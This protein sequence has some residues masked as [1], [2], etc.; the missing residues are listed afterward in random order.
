M[1]KILFIIFICPAFAFAQQYSLNNF[2]RN[3]LDK[4][5]TNNSV[6]IHSSFLPLNKATIG[7]YEIDDKFLF[8]KSEDPLIGDRIK[9]TWLWRVIRYEDLIHF[10]DDDFSIIAN[11]ISCFEIIKDETGILKGDLPLSVNTRGFEIKG[12]IGQS[13]G[14]YTALYEN[15]AFYP[16]YINGFIEKHLVVPGQGMSKI[17]QEKGHDF[18]RAE[19]HISFSH[20][21][22]YLFLNVT[23]GHGKH[24]VGNGYRSLLL[25]DNA[26]NYPFV[27]INATAGKY[28]YSLMYASFHSFDE[29]YY[30]YHYRKHG[31][32]AYLSRLFGEKVE[33]SLFESIIWKTSDGSTYSKK[34][35]ANYFNPL[36]LSRLP[37]YSLDDEHNMMLGLNAKYDISKSVRLYGQAVLD[38]LDFSETGTKGYIENRYGF[39]AG[40]KYLG[41]TKEESL[42]KNLFMTAEY[43]YSRPYTYSHTNPLQNY[44]HLNQSLAHPLGSGFREL[45]TIFDYS[46]RSINLMFKYS[47]AIFSD[48]T[49]DSHFGSDIFQSLNSAS[50]GIDSHDNSIGQGVEAN[51]QHIDLKLSFIL[52]PHN[53]LRLFVGTNIRNLKSG[54]ITSKTNFIT[55]GLKSAINNYYFDF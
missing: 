20:D 54:D 37:F 15:Q 26:F 2:Y 30:N 41:S 5:F 39:Q 51:L 40:I 49:E 7:Y 47:T 22:D 19:A 52:K 18:S 23:L 3:L 27:K 55:F 11:S 31:T 8:P 10:K 14:Y 32:F 36:I 34:F 45:L 53:N 16:E 21:F 4:E 43:N 42:L 44:S 17:F 35:T 46:Y 50:N 29:V 28:F 13:I 9:N 24:F 6:P 33:I 38:D 12:R 1:K 25:S 48:D